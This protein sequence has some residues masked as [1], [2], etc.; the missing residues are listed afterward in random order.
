MGALALGCHPSATPKPQNVPSAGTLG[1]P[2]GGKG[3]SPVVLVGGSLIFRAH[4]NPWQPVSATEYYVSPG[5]SVKTIV[6]K[7]KPA[8]DSETGGNTGDDNDATTDEIRV[9]V[10]Q[11][12]TWQIDEYAGSAVVTT[13]SLNADGTIHLVQTGSVYLCPTDGKPKNKI[14]FTQDA[15]CKNPVTFTQVGIS[16]TYPAQQ[17]QPKTITLGNLACVDENLN[18]GNCRIVLRN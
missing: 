14:E 15:G 6:V 8:Q 12:T 18:Q 3:D 10:S 16:A 11:A 2:F 9:D 13:L 4:L 7:A 1:V 17:G 5:S